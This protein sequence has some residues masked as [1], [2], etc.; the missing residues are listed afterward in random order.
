[1]HPRVLRELADAV[2]QTLSLIFEKSHHS[3]EVP[4]EERKGNI[5]LIFKKSRE[6]DSGNYQ[7]VNFPCREKSGNRSSW[8]LGYQGTCKRS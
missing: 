7:P 8:K 4:G 5:T 6:V 1:M 3:G 2:T